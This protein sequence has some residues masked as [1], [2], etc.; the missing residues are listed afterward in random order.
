MKKKLVSL[1]LAFVMA[2]STAPLSFAE[3][4]KTVAGL[5]NF[6]KTNTY[7][8][9][10][11][12]DVKNSDWFAENVKTAYEYGLVKGSSSTAFNPTGKLTVAETIVLAC[13]LH[14]IYNGGD[15]NFTQGSPWYQVYVDYATENDIISGGY[16]YDSAITRFSFVN[17][18]SNA[19]PKEVFNEINTIESGKIPD[20]EENSI[21]EPIYLFYRAGILT[22]S[23]KYGTFNPNSNIQR[24]EVA[25]IITRMAD[26]SQRK[27]F[28]VE[29]KVWIP[30]SIELAGQTTISVG[31][32]VVWNVTISPSKANQWVQWISGNPSVATVDANGNIK[33]LKVGQSNI[34]AITSNGIKK[35]VLITVQ[36]SNKI[37]S[38]SANN[39]KTKL[40]DT[41]TVTITFVSDLYDSIS[42]EVDNE[43][44]LSCEWG[45]WD[46]YNT[47]L[48]ITPRNSGATSIRVYVTE[49]PN[50]YETIYVTVAAPLTPAD[51]TT[52]TIEGVGQE[53]KQYNTGL[54]NTNKLHSATY[55]INNYPNDTVAIWVDFVVSCTNCVDYNGYIRLRYNLY[56]SSGVVVKTD[57]TITQ[58][59]KTY[60]QYAGS[61]VFS[62]LPPDDYK[63]VFSSAY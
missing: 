17:I 16:L 37:I 59:T 56:N 42:Y 38:L 6:T 45:E 49:A 14:N 28:Q 15:G 1:L 26:A 4:A 13:R 60:T 46:G 12:S 27:T 63:L 24:S 48:Y 19:L 22:G 23:D 55:R 9:G 31:D 40:N 34:T 33:G 18:L 58:F 25:T 10:Q 32:S 7:V 62:D 29:D 47:E 43:S 35:T 30:E 52:L 36:Q 39:I 21:N 2:L 5:E 3:D 50:I 57:K 61:L 8:D 41:E 51:L 54:P 53:F 20:V 11:F 44:M